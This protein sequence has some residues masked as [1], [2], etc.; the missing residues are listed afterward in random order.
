MV[1][2]HGAFVGII[3]AIILFILALIGFGVGAGLTD[4]II[5]QLSV[6]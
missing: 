4:I 1:L 3:A 6:Q 5:L 2:S